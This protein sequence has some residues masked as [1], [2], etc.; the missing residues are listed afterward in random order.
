MSSLHGN[1][2]N[3]LSY[4]SKRI[5]LF[6]EI[7]D[8]FYSQVAI[9][10]SFFSSSLNDE[11]SLSASTQAST[12]W[13]S[14]WAFKFGGKILY[15]ALNPERETFPSENRKKNL[16]VQFASTEIRSHHIKITFGM[17]RNSIAFSYLYLQY[18]QER[19]EEVNASAIVWE[20]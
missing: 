19:F 15:A 8:I 2:N 7:C 4:A 9:T 6:V 12:C 20:K 17:V 11:F 18:P 14:S 5:K 10:T 1:R 3:I 13:P 16:N